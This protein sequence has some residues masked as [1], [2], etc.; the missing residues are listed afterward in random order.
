MM[1]RGVPVK[2]STW[3]SSEWKHAWRWFSVQLGVVIASASLLYGQ[4]DFLQELIG[5]KWYGAI[6]TVL[7]IAM[8]YN[9]IRKKHR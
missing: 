5:P 7:G 8:V 3:I 4:V 6:N 2:L 1:F 9:A